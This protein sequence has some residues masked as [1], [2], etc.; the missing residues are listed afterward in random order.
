MSSTPANGYQW[1]LNGAPIAG[2]TQ[3]DWIPLVN[4]NYSVEITDAN[5]CSAMSLPVY[6]GTVGMSE[7]TTGMFRA[8]P[9]PADE[10][11]TIEG[12]PS[13]SDVLL[14]DAGG[15][16]VRTMRAVA[17]GTVRMDVEDLAPGTYLL[18]VRS[19]SRDERATVLVR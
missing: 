15:R 6:F 14:F 8:Y 4:G 18:E 11:L 10:V 7:A 1:Y 13:A 12:V 5:G 2:A 16:M 17:Q 9:Q 19:G 3:Q